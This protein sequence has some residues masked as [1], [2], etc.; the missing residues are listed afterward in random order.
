LLGL[1]AVGPASDLPAG[2]RAVRVDLGV[3]SKGRTWPVQ[4]L[5]CRQAPNVFAPGS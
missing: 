2:R 1:P 5:R 4:G 3:G